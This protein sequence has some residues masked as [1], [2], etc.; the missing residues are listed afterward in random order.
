MANLNSNAAYD[1]SRF[2][3]RKTQA[4]DRKNNVVKLPEPKARPK[5]KLTFAMAFKRFACCAFVI[6]IL[7]TMIYGYVSVNELTTGID[8]TQKKLNEATSEYTQLQMAAA[9]KMSLDYVEEYAQKELG[10]QKMQPS[11]IT[12]VHLNDSD[13]VEVL[14]DTSEKSLFEKIK[15]FF[16]DILS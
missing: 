12:Y 1:F 9:S 2:E 13:K 3:N 8:K 16:S 11:Q 5:H 6:G 15:D 7:G 4:A 14:A 10:M